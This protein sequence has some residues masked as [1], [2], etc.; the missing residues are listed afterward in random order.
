MDL[1]RKPGKGIQHTPDHV[2]DR[3]ATNHLDLRRLGS[4]RTPQQAS[5][6]LRLP[7]TD[8]RL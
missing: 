8:G 2:L 6:D 1:L 3:P 5:R 4:Q 7:P